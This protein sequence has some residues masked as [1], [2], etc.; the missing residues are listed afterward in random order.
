M[1]CM[2]EFGPRIVF[3][4]IVNTVPPSTDLLRD[5]SRKVDGVRMVLVGAPKDANYTIAAVKHGVRDFLTHPADPKELRAVLQ[6]AGI[7]LDAAE[8]RSDDRPSAPRPAEGKIVTVCSPKGGMGAT[9]LTAN[10]GAVITRKAGVSVIACELASQCGDLSTYLDLGPHYTIMDLIRQSSA[11]D[12][13]FV[14][15][16]IQKH[17]SGLDVLAGPVYAQDQLDPSQLKEL[18]FILNHLKRKYELVLIDAGGAH[19]GILEFALMQ[20]DMILIVGSL[21]IPSLKGLSAMYRRLIRLMYD[22]AKIH[23]IINRYNAKHQIGVREFEKKIEHPVDSCLINQYAL[24]SESVN[25]GKTLF[26]LDPANELVQNLS[27]LGGSIVEK[28]GIESRSADPAARPSAPKLVGKLAGLLK[29]G[30]R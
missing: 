12:D 1:A 21:D 23:I 6:E 30:A 5:M 4:D 17:G 24:C 26:E 16:V 2:Q 3:I 18:H 11:L 8:V 19:A 10:L 7:D 13:S 27:A 15:G 20:S 28:L 25:T 14:Q 29:K 22:P 9:L